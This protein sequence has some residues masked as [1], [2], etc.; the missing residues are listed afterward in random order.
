LIRYLESGD[1][2]QTFAGNLSRYLV[3]AIKFTEGDVVA[4]SL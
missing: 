1:P 2:Q 4:A 3:I